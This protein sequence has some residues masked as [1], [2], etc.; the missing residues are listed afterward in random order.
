M[1]L[2]HKVSIVCPPL[3][4]TLIQRKILWHLLPREK[5][6]QTLKTTNKPAEDSSLNKNKKSFESSGSSQLKWFCL[7]EKAQ[8]ELLLL[9]SAEAR[10]AAEHP[11]AP[12]TLPPT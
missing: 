11:T 6:K 1:S 9:S 3:L 10:D 12:L 5:N 8:Q 4:F 7:V 2:L